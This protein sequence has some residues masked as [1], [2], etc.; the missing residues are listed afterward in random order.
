MDL[1]LPG[2]LGVT[3]K[4]RTLEAKISMDW[5]VVS[6]Q[7]P[8]ITYDPSHAKITTANKPKTKLNRATS[9]WLSYRNEMLPEH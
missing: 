9:K 8:A 2:F 5:K 1:H 7:T 4:H 6:R 3:K